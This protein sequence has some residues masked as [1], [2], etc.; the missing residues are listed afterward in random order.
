MNQNKKLA[1]A[2]EAIKVA[3]GVECE[4]NESFLSS[5]PMGPEGKNTFT[6]QIPCYDGSVLNPTQ[7]GQLV[8]TYYGTEKND[9]L[10]NDNLQVGDLVKIEF[11]VFK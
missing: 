8:I 7:L 5:Q 4:A 9:G 3:A 10:Q 2:V 6:Q 1:A 11:E